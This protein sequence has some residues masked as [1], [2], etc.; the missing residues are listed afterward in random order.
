MRAGLSTKLLQPT[1][2]WLNRPACGANHTLE[3][4]QASGWEGRELTRE[5]ARDVI[6]IHRLWPALRV[7]Y[8]IR[9]GGPP[10]IVECQQIES[11]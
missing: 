8:I 11:R 10:E 6:A 1:G 9:C 4:G 3:G 5:A 7:Q 2:G